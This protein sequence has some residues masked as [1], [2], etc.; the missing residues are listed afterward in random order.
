M[1]SEFISQAIRMRAKLY[2]IMLWD[3]ELPELVVSEPIES[4]LVLKKTQSILSYP[5]I[6]LSTHK[7]DPNPNNLTETV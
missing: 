5:N 4:L 2:L 6:E 1:E 3:P 7:Y